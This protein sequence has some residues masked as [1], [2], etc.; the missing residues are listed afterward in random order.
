MLK[1]LAALA[2]LCGLL[3]LIQFAVKRHRA[4][5]LADP[6]RNRAAL[7][8]Y[9]CLERL[10]RWGGRMDPQGVE[11]AEKAK[12][13]AHTLTEEELAVLTRLVARE[14]TRL[15]AGLAWWRRLPFRYLWGMPS[16]PVFDRDL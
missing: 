12:Y 2:G 15:A 1:A 6:D 16:P 9:R 3:W 7:Y 11:L 4:Q 5:R 10:E 13:S 14:R 8:A